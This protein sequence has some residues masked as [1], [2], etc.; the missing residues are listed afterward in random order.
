MPR[1]MNIEQ[2]KV[3]VQNS[4]THKSVLV[5]FFNFKYNRILEVQKQWTSCLITNLINRK[6]YTYIHLA[7][8]NKIFSYH[9]FA[10]P[11]HLSMEIGKTTILQA[12][13]TTDNGCYLQDEEGNE[14]L[15]QMPT[16]LLHYK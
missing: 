13:R 3:S 9:S 15:C 14:V 6:F 8:V 16:W 11:L 4:Q 7:N 1:S 12:A 10:L 5:Y 2:N